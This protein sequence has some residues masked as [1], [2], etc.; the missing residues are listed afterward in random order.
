[1][2]EALHEAELPSTVSESHSKESSVILS[3]FRCLVFVGAL[4]VV[5][6]S[7]SASPI[8]LNFDG[9]GDFDLLTNQFP[10]LTFSNAVALTSGTSL[11]EFDFPPRSG[12][13]VVVDNDGPMSINF[14]ASVYSLTGYFTYSSPVTLT[15]FDA[16][17]NILGSVTSSLLENFVS[18]NTPNP[19]EY[20]SFESFVGIRSVTFAGSAFGGSFVLDDLTYDD[21]R[22]TAR[23]PEPTS[24]AV[25]LVGSALALVARRRRRLVRSKGNE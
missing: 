7:A 4:F 6:A 8:T 1:M 18:S 12:T 11:N 9:L 10:G 3:R 22:S 19:N 25:V 20:L 14:A 2:A 24:L 21:E 23:V 15:A 13:N 16:D 17:N 5:S